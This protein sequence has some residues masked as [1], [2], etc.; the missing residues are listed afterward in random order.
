METTT[1]KC[2]HCG[3]VG[4]TPLTKRLQTSL[5]NGG[6]YDLCPECNKRGHRKNV[7]INR[8]VVE[9]SFKYIK[10]PDFQLEAVFLIGYLN[11]PIGLYH[12]LYN[13]RL[14]NWFDVPARW[15]KNTVM[16]VVTKANVDAFIKA[17]NEVG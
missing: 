17:I 5:T 13:H 3:W 9:R 12:C 15:N 10:D 7:T 14:L 1:F 6:T 16:K 11:L 4:T 8:I 2:E